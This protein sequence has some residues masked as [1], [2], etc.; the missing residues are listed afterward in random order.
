M[1]LRTKLTTDHFTCENLLSWLVFVHLLLLT[2]LLLI[3]QVGAD[4]KCDPSFQA[5]FV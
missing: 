5:N 2:S 4:R 1:V 3:E